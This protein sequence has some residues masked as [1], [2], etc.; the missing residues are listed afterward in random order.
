MKLTL[1]VATGLGSEL[2]ARLYGSYGRRIR[3]VV[4][5]SIDAGAKNFF[6]NFDASTPE[7]KITF[8]DDGSGMT[9]EIIMSE[10][11][12]IGGSSKRNDPHKIGRIGI[13]F[14]AM[15]GLGKKIKVQTR[16]RKGKAFQE[17]T[18]SIDTGYLF[19]ESLRSQDITKINIA[20]MQTG[21]TIEKPF[22]TFTY[23]EITNL[24]K[25]FLNYLLNK[26]H[27]LKFDLRRILPL[28][29][30]DNCPLFDHLKETVEGQNLMSYLK[31][32]N[33]I[34]FWYRDTELLNRLAYYEDGWGCVG[35]K[36]GNPE[37][38]NIYILD[39]NI[40]SS[41]GQ[42]IS[43]KG[44]LILTSKSPMDKWRGFVSRVKNVA[45]EE[46]GPLNLPVTQPTYWARHTGEL[47]ID[48]IDDNMAL[49]MDRTS[50]NYE[51][52][53][54]IKISDKLEKWV[55]QIFTKSEKI[56]RERTS[57]KYKKNLPNQKPDPDEENKQHE[58]QNNFSG[59]ACPPPAQTGGIA[60]EKEETNQN[61]TD[62]EAIAIAP[63]NEGSIKVETVN[64][65]NITTTIKYKGF[66]WSVS[67]K[68]FEHENSLGDI[69]RDT[70]DIYLNS[71]NP[72]ISEGNSDIMK[73]CAY[74]VLLQN[75]AVDEIDQGEKE[76]IDNAILV[77]TKALIKGVGA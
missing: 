61:Q 39:T 67:T 7:G 18:L 68:L 64:K 8:L 1:N 53:D 13:G 21:I 23:I 33:T 73:L 62:H 36:G 46:N 22:E 51:F 75:P 14:L 59:N 11:L 29:Y 19:D 5:N 56:R 57:R 24:S 63:D 6:M 76:K 47:F 38:W 43:L 26:E 45:V 52:D 40:P 35:K 69:I 58:N 41:N 17:L 28:P 50:F 74:F 42:D 66:T 34:S 20:D 54:M 12:K 37:I 44:Y 55:T 60:S 32:L 70:K 16:S 4:G 25:P 31:S 30:P 9:E 72:L 49:N 77:L 48:N 2:V 27:D 15:A 10:F 3:E 65:T 71:G